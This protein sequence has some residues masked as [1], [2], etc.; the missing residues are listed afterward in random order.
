MS[1]A[2][3]MSAKEIKTRAAQWLERQERPDWSEKDR[4]ELEEWLAQSTAHEVAYVRLESAWARTERLVVLRPLAAA[5]ANT[6]E[7]IGRKHFAPV[8]IRAAAVFTLVAALAV[9][10]YYTLQPLDRTYST[11]VGGRE[12]LTFADGT[13]IELNTN[14]V[15][16]ARMT[17]DQRIVWLNRGEAFFQVKHDAT[18]PFIVMIGE[19]RVTDIGT[20]F[21]IRRGQNDVQVAVTQGRVTFDAPGVASQAALLKQ[22]DVAVAS[23]QSMSVTRKTTQALSDELGWRR[24]IIVF[25]HTTLADAAAELNRYNRVKLIV[26]DPLAARRTIGA[27][28][29]TSDVEL[30]AR[31]A[32]VA[33]GLHVADRGN[34]IE[35]SH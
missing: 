27:T 13:R 16:R 26:T 33:L 29:R 31:V 30:F 5:K 18:H 23:A 3:M 7:Q 4:A 24:G 25:R 15:L 12:T 22:G 20:Q 6:P 28:F 8:L 32:E 9:G 10:A 19:H 2:H 11:P 1:E 35:V 21:S 17:T 14:T 34:E